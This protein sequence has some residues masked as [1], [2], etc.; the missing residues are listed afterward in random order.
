MLCEEHSLEQSLAALV[1]KIQEEVKTARA[2]GQIRATERKYVRLRSVE[3]EYGPQGVSRSSQRYEEVTKEDW[4]YAAQPILPRI[5]NTNE[6]SE[7]L[8]W[9]KRFWPANH[10]FSHRFLAFAYALTFGFVMRGDEYRAEADNLAAMYAKENRG[11]EIPYEIE[12]RLSRLVVLPL[13]LCFAVGDLSVE[14][15]QTTP[16]DV[17]T[18]VDCESAPMMA[19]VPNFS[20]P[21]SP[22][23]VMILSRLAQSSNDIRK[24]SWRAIA[25]LRLFSLT[26]VRALSSKVRA[27]AFNDIC[28]QAVEG[29]SQYFDGSETVVLNEQD[30]ER[31]K[32]FWQKAQKLIPEHFYWAPGDTKYDHIGVAYRRY[33]DALENDPI[34]E[35]RLANIVMG[36]ESL[37]IGGGEQ[38]GDL[39]YRLRIRTAKL[40]G[41]LQGSPQGILD[42]LKVAYGVRSTFEHGD[43]V[44]AKTIHKIELAHGGLP[45]LTRTV[46]ECL[47]QSILL[48]LFWQPKKE[49][50][51]QTIDGALVD[52][53]KDI[54]LAAELSELRE[55]IL[56]STSVQ[57]Q[58]H[59]K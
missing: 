7:A 25:I 3:F 15:R 33:C 30:G 9:C 8:G 42:A 14:I 16:T 50:F 24:E 19:I 41:C 21:G 10:N 5:E 28:V 13:K 11:E 53:E 23:A 4:R 51:I 56:R 46:H 20:P 52:R 40:L 18:E 26:S 1:S 22:S 44:S 35:R 2:Q 27:D 57:G 47:R 6:Y 49:T 31:L 34:V 59:V 39:A 58:G 32:A 29:T 38:Q 45:G 43:Q 17:E 48:A 55:L 54:A 37:F 12:V 36:M